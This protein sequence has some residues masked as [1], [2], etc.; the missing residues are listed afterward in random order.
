MRL[1][2]YFYDVLG[3]NGWTKIDDQINDF[4]KKTKCKIVDVK[5]QIDSHD[6]N[7]ALLIYEVD[8]K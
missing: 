8:E 7:K 5:Y 2:K 1:T 3:Y 4:V 6:N